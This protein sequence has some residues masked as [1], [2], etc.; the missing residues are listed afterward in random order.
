MCAFIYLESIAH[1]N[2]LASSSLLLRT[3]VWRFCTLDFFHFCCNVFFLMAL[4]IKQVEYTTNNLQR[5]IKSHCDISSILFR[6]CCSKVDNEMIFAASRHR[7]FEYKYQYKNYVISSCR[8][9]KMFG[10]LLFTPN[11]NLLHVTFSFNLMPAISFSKLTIPVN[12]LA[13]LG[14]SNLYIIVC[15][16]NQPCYGAFHFIHRL[17][18]VLFLFGFANIT[19]THR[20]II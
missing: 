1:Y 9:C 8:Q 10:F 13:N 12:R 18:R 20:F 3:Y 4:K 6:N 17:C 11:E 19:F 16:L 14:V 2:I 15:P 7:Q 5:P